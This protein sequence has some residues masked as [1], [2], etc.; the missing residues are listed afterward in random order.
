MLEAD[1][2][3]IPGEPGGQL[4]SSAVSKHLSLVFWELD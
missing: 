2:G 3:Y 1:L 4:T